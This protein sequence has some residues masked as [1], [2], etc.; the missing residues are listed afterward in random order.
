M[1]ESPSQLCRG[2]SSFTHEIEE[3]TFFREDG[4][5]QLRQ[6]LAAQ[7]RHRDETVLIGM[8]QVAR[9]DRDAGYL[10]RNACADDSVIR[11]ARYRAAREI[12]KAHFAN[13]AQIAHTAVAHQADRS[14]A[15][16]NGR[17]HFPRMRG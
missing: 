14:Q 5:D 9:P 12:M 4:L 10:D 13:G 15:S 16:K 2:E 1:K 6:T 8:Q 3:L 17:H 7:L 11:V